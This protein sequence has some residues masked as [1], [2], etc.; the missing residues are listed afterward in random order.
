MRMQI[1]FVAKGTIQK[2]KSN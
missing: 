1:I 2:H